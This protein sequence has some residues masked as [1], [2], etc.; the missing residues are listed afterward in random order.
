MK[1]VTFSS[2]DDASQYLADYIIHKIKSFKPTASKPFVLGLPTGSSPEG[3]YARLVAA[4][5]QGRISFK[6]VVTFNMDEYLGLAPENPQSYHYFMFDKL[7]N[8]IDIPRENINILN[9]LAKDVEKECADY[10]GKI[11][12]Y[13]RINLFLG[14]LG[15]EG[16]LAFNEAGS[17]RDSKTRKV[18]LVE[19]TI[20]A[21]C[22]F[23]DNDESKVPKHALSVGISTILENSDEVALIVLGENKRFALDKTIN[24]KK[25]DP[26]YPSSYL[27]D[28]DNVLI[29]CDNAAA[30][31]KF[32]L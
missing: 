17:T 24:G 25:N 22:R 13:E 29:V 28:H 20:K 23:F 19:S 32:K 9:G 15:P 18:A 31:L 6:N 12:K 5:K 8:H 1:Q 26:K 16:H 10:E 3:I 2:S 7:F 27:Q 11:K 30:G 4:Y 14:G 21:N